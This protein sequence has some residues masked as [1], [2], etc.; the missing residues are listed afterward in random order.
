MNAQPSILLVLSLAAWAPAS[1]SDWPSWRG[2]EQNG[3]SRDT[4]LPETWSPEGENLLWKKPYG[5][6]T[7][8]VV[9]QGRLFL[10]GLGGDS[11]QT[12][13]ERVLCL[14]AESGDFIWEYAFNVF[15]TD[16]VDHRVAWANPV[17]DPETGNVYVH[18]AQGLLVC[19]SRGGK[20]LW[21][22]SLTEE[23]GRISGYGGRTHTP[24]VDEDRLVISFVNSS[25]GPDSR[26]KH[27]YLALD[28][29]TGKIVWWSDP[30]DAPL[31]TTYSTPVVAVVGGVRLLVAGC[32]DG[33]ILAIKARTGEKVWSFRLSKLGVNASVVVEGDRVYAC[34]SE[35]NIDNQKLGRVV[36]IDAR[37]R[38]DVT[39]T[40]EVWRAD[41]V[42]AGYSSP[43]IDAGKLY[44]IDNSANLFCFD[45]GSGRKL[46]VHNVGTVMKGSPVLADGKVYTGAVSGSFYILKPEDS[47]CRTLSHVNFE[48][49]DGRVLELNG[50]PCVASGRVYF[51]TKDALYAI[52]KRP[53][54]GGASSSQ[55]RGLPPEPPSDPAAK[56]VHLQVVPAEVTLAAGES[57]SFE[58]RLF[59]ASGRMLGA[60]KPQWSLA[61]LAAALD[62]AAG[63]VAIPETSGS[64]GG[65][66]KASHQGLEASARVRVL[67]RLPLKVTFDEVP[68]QKTPGGW[69]GASPL[70]FQV[71]PDG[72]GSGNKLLK[73][74]ADNPR[75]VDGDIFFGH[76]S[77][78]DYTLQADV[79]VTETRRNM[80]NA[81]LILN[82]YH[83]QL[84]GN[85]Q[86]ARIVAWISMPRIEK[87]MDFK[88]KPGVW[89]T[90]KLRVD[91]RGESG[92]VRGKIWPRQDAEPESW[93]LEVEDPR[94]EQNGSPG[95]HSY[96]AGATEQRPGSEVY[97]DNVSVTPNR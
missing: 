56:P 34:H 50:S 44:V 51:A 72:A 88:W 12:L 52:G 73:K 93:T 90:L 85:Q 6:R 70:K 7:A 38:G 77:W 24:I 62:V 3:V 80:G 17:A 79:M 78:R 96:A 68:D 82:R 60:C 13:H 25:W 71:L 33:T 5:S 94:I 30:G 64:Q 39:K 83:L 42:G 95:L 66:L 22:R 43:A 27:R 10:F 86:R 69:V 74:L 59:D 15:L 8:P 36:C 89:Y 49:E 91:A 92:T 20:L 31:D 61:G 11:P 21:E 87:R 54:R 84:M 46:W 29:R 40:H 55:P 65:V 37:G 48:T 2:P 35:E 32:A 26:P 16:I 58:A 53:W 97:F 45:A 4:G 1:A 47:G 67:P 63:K 81:G 75:L 41:E 19:L 18:G 14:D 9:F 28:K 57:E 23:F 76:P